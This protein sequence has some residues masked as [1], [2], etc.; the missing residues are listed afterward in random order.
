MAVKLSFNLDEPT[1]GSIVDDSVISRY[2]P[3]NIQEKL[4]EVTTKTNVLQQF[5]LNLYNMD[6]GFV[7]APFCSVL[8]IIANHYRYTYS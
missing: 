3:D 7:F 4:L 2:I 6:S 1:G 8:C 5:L